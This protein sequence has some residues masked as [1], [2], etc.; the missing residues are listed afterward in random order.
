MLCAKQGASRI[1]ALEPIDANCRIIESVLAANR[2]LA[3]RV[4]LLRVAASDSEGEEQLEYGA[5]DS[6]AQ[7]VHRDV[8]T[9][10][11]RPLRTQSITVRTSTL[12]ALLKSGV[13]PPTIIKID[14]EG[15]EH[16]ALKGSVQLL[17]QHKPILI[18][19]VHNMEACRLCL[20]LLESV[21]YSTWE[22]TTRGLR[23]LRVDSSITGT[24]LRCT[25][26]LQMV[27]QMPPHR[28]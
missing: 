6:E 9:S 10:K 11:R 24:F 15:A 4:Q 12:D 17:T 3:S 26:L 22:I 13:I 23:R 5:S 8:Q 19:E 21:D 2:A 20:E 27:Q 1:V 7:L 14:I 28:R 16:L 18:I 25:G